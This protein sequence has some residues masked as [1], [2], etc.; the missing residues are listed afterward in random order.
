[1]SAAP[2][3]RIRIAAMILAA[4]IG[5]ALAIALMPDRAPV[6]TPPEQTLPA[7]TSPDVPSEPIRQ[8]EIAEHGRASLAAS[9]IAR[10]G[11]LTLSLELPDEARGDGVRSVRIVSV[12]GRRLEI[13]SEPDA[14]TGIRLELD[15]AFFKPGLYMIHVDTA[16]QHALHFRR[17]VLDLK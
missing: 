7:T 10:D 11:P 5:I 3:R 1:M 8:I 9:A 14:E 6:S 12:D 13:Q 4:T 17:Y 2:N 16:E 15:P